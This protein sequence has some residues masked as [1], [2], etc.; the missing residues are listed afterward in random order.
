[1]PE[2]PD[3]GVLVVSRR[4]KP[5]REKEYAEW[6][7]RIIGAASGFPGYRGV[8]TIA[9]AGPESDVRYLVWRFDSAKS[10]EAWESSETRNRLTDEVRSY[11]D[12]HYEK[13]SGME[14]WF[15][16]PD[17]HRVVAPPRWKMFL[18]TLLAVYPVSLAARYLL[19]PFL[20][21]WPLYAT[22]AIYSSILVGVLTYFAMPKLSWLLRRWLYPTR[23]K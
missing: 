7:Q 17:V 11:S 4:I 13:S 20:A 6:L 21:T 1:M 16:L 19:T 8:T 15:S 23:P 18:A 5:G 14:T 3:E 2:A 22:T 12:Q 10:L 9:P